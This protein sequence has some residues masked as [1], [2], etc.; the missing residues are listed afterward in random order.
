MGELEEF[1]RRIA[2]T[3]RPEW[4]QIPDPKSEQWQAEFDA[5]V[6]AYLERGEGA[7]E[8]YPKRTESASPLPPIDLSGVSPEERFA[9]A[10][11]AHAM[12]EGLWLQGRREL[13]AVEQCARSA[14]LRLDD[15][16]AYALRL[17]GT[18]YSPPENA[19]VRDPTQHYEMF[20]QYHF[21]GVPD[22]GQMHASRLFAL[23]RLEQQSSAP[24]VVFEQASE[25]FHRM[26]LECSTPGAVVHYQT[27]RT[28]TQQVDPQSG[29]PAV[30]TTAPAVYDPS[31]KFNFRTDC[32]PFVVFAWSTCEGLRPSEMVRA[33]YRPPATA[34]V[35]EAG[36]AKQTFGFFLGSGER[37]GRSAHGGAASLEVGRELPQR[38]HL[39]RVP[40]DCKLRVL[41]GQREIELGPDQPLVPVGDELEP[42]DGGHVTVHEAVAE[43]QGCNALHGSVGLGGVVGRCAQLEGGFELT[44]QGRHH[45]VDLRLQLRPQ[46]VREGSGHQVD[47][48][49]LLQQAEAVDQV[50]AGVLAVE[51]GRAAAPVH[52]RGHSAAEDALVVLGAFVLRPNRGHVGDE[53]ADGVE[54][55]RG[56]DVEGG[57]G[58]HVEGVAAGKGDH[59]ALLDGREH[60]L[61]P[62]RAHF[63]KFYDKYAFVGVFIVLF[64]VGRI[65]LS[66]V[67]PPVVSACPGILV[68]MSVTVGCGIARCYLG[69][70]VARSSGNL[71]VA[72]GGVPAMQGRGSLL[73]GRR[74][75]D[76]N[77]NGSRSHGPG[78]GQMVR[79]PAD[80]GVHN[81]NGGEKVDDGAASDETLD[82]AD[83]VSLHHLAELGLQ[84]VRQ[85][86]EDAA[87]VA[88]SREENSAVVQS[89]GLVEGE[90]GVA[91]EP[92]DAVRHEGHAA[93]QVLQHAGHRFAATA[94]VHRDRA[95]VGDEALQRY[96]AEDAAHAPDE[97]VEVSRAQPKELEHAEGARVGCV[98][99]ALEDA[100][101]PDLVGVLVW[102]R[103]R[104]HEGVRVA[105]GD[106]AGLVKGRAQ[107]GPQ[108]PRSP[109]HPQE[110]DLADAVE[111]GRQTLGRLQEHGGAPEVL[112]LVEGVAEGLG[113]DEAL[114]RLEHALEAGRAGARGQRLAG[115]SVVVD[116]AHRRVQVLH[117]LEE[118][119]E[120]LLGERNLGA[121]PL[122]L[123]VDSAPTK[124]LQLA[125]CLGDALGH[126]L[127]AL[128]HGGG[129]VDHGP[130]LPLRLPQA[131]YAALEQ[132]DADVGHGTGRPGG[133]GGS[134]SL[135]EDLV[136]AGQHAGDSRRLEL[137]RF[138]ALEAVFRPLPGLHGPKRAVTLLALQL[139]PP[140]LLAA[141]L[142]V[143][144]GVAAVPRE[145]LDAVVGELAGHHLDVGRLVVDVALVL[146]E[147][148]E[149]VQHQPADDGVDD[150][151]LLALQ[152][153]REH[154]ALPAVRGGA[155]DVELAAVEHRESAADVQVAVEPVAQGLLAV[156]ADDLDDVGVVE[157]AAGL[158]A[159]LVLG[160]QPLAA[161]LGVGDGGCLVERL[162][163]GCYGGFRCVRNMGERAAVGGGEHAVGGPAGCPASEGQ[164]AGIHGLR[165]YLW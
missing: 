84:R 12:M 148:V 15:V 160:R 56:R 8:Y 149:D 35:G 67:G 7:C 120:A 94:G 26:R 115:D 76:A 139:Q 86:A 68:I 75:V 151:P 88:G 39:R 19:N 103:R 125:S 110:A 122:Q 33:E 22:V 135:L 126:V 40:V 78:G 54:H 130:E 101:Q 81:H 5:A 89:G 82:A 134:R 24:R 121:Q 153:R 52:S 146:D 107:R 38:A 90:P 20:P 127:D 46:G 72:P 132:R 4:Q 136:R 124:V 138:E 123:R 99:V 111:V 147:V 165:L 13:A 131:R 159:G 57:R 93:L 2:A 80:V 53:L 129:A 161:H 156:G 97:V 142:G 96:L 66:V 133:R 155:E 11:R 91:V 21:L 58:V 163:K 60:L 117:E 112:Q 43:N 64:D 116:A 102:A 73:R 141:A 63:N 31:K 137:E 79:Q 18:T 55:V 48:E 83:R 98:G 30:Y 49:R 17:R 92:L 145:V 152:L 59:N 29:Q 69:A 85:Q 6:D 128:E 32:L 45:G 28:N 162:W 36:A 25:E 144:E 119:G 106:V 109:L 95:G 50:G 157:D 140:A 16:V 70:M 71:V 65:R 9:L 113:R 1:A 34:S 44:Q 37:Q 143:L 62:G 10:R 158:V 42:L 51:L 23:S 100:A 114:R 41:V 150:Q 47:G 104:G 61:A 154:D 105:Q 3:V 164:Q 74:A 77:P 14:P 108:A 118:G 27:Q 87:K